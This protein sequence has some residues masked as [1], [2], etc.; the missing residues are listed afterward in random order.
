MDYEANDNP[1][2]TPEM[3]GR[4]PEPAPAEQ[5][6]ER[7]DLIR[8]LIIREIENRLSQAWSRAGNIDGARSEISHAQIAL[9]QLLAEVKR[10]D[11]II[12]AARPAPTDAK[13]LREALEEIARPGVG[14]ANIFADHPEETIDKYYA[15]Y[16]YCMRQIDRRREIAHAALEAPKEQA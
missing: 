14:L 6:E 1:S 5:G 8:E 10:L 16:K 11:A 4:Y 12:L 15:A 9:G 13:A 2:E 7:V 3:E